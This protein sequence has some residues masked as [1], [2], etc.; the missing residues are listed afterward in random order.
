[1]SAVSIVV[2]VYNTEMYLEECLSSICA[3]TLSD[4]EI[5]CVNDGSNDESGSILNRFAARDNRIK[6]IHKANT[7]YGHSM[8]MG[9][10]A[11]SGEYIGIVESD[12][13][14][15]QEMM[16]T[17]Y[18]AAEIYQVDFVKADFYRFV[19]Q[20]DG[21]IRK[22]YDALSGQAYYYNRVFCPS[23][24]IISFKFP[25]NIWCG[26]YRTDFIK[27]NGIRF[28]ESPGASFQ[29]NG[30]WFQTF[31]LAE[32]AVLLNKPL[33]M[34]RR[35][36]PLSSVYCPDKVYAICMEYDYIRQWVGKLPG[37]QKKYKY[38]C[39]EGRI[40][41]YFRT[42]DRIAD[43][44]K[45]EFY[46]K[47]REDYLNLKNTGE[48]AETFFPFEWKARIDKIIENPREAC[49]MEMAERNRYQKIIGGF[50]DIIIYGA[51]AY[52]RK[53]FDALGRMGARDCVAYFAVTDKRDNPPTLFGIPVVEFSSLS[54]EFC[55]KALVIVAVKA[56]ARE[57]II[58]N[59]RTYGYRHYTDSELLFE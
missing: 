23:D 29:D 9:I 56:D 41:N 13:W 1:M 45:E 36:N 32:R 34:N 55:Q 52:G 58:Q 22:H 31:A 50:R 38:L 44:Y 39:A 25:I 54:A 47:F 33:Y 17:L 20:A 57:Q 30:F 27:E 48:L 5:I 21:V 46:I 49:R 2:P 19:R 28:H 40:G 37:N 11:A 8:N 51:G 24:E 53:A 18:E 42:I 16:Q 3:Q 10:E 7:G 26:I 35:D 43:S 14:I 4:I 59:I 15:P 6:V 12:D